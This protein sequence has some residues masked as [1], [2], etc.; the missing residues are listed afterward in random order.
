VNCFIS[1][2]QAD[3]AWAEWIAWQLEESGLQTILQAWD[4]HAGSNFILEM[5]SAAKRAQRTIVV[6]STS[7]VNAAYTHPEWASALARD[8]TGEKRVLLPVRVQECTLTGLLAQVVYVDLVGLT[9][10]EAKRMLLSQ[11]QGERGKPLA[12]PRF[13]GRSAGPATEAPPYPAADV[14]ASITET[15]APICRTPSIADSETEVFRKA[16]QDLLP[17]VGPVAKILVRRAAAKAGTTADLYTELAAAIPMESERQKF[18]RLAT[19][20]SG[21]SASRSRAPNGGSKHQHLGKFSA[22]LLEQLRRELMVHIGPV[23]KLAINEESSSATTLEDLYR[24]LGEHV[25][26]GAER[27]AFL[28]RLPKAC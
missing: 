24:R 4:F 15:H 23:A 9:Q 22:S 8:P 25:P 12:A 19:D 3:L 13:P 1:Y 21:T 6:L 16:E 20:R 26:A 5:D 27:L 28:E 10:I 7:Y 11:V 14:S 18:L 17:Y 2:T